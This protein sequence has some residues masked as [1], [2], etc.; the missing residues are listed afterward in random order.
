MGQREAPPS[1]CKHLLPWSRPWAYAHTL[2]L[3]GSAALHGKHILSFLRWLGSRWRTGQPRDVLPKEGKEM[4]AQAAPQTPVAHVHTVLAHLVIWSKG[5][6]VWQQDALRRLYLTGKLLDADLAEL[7]RLC[8]EP[9]GLLGKDESSVTAEPIESAHIPAQLPSS[10]PVSLKLVGQTQN[11]NALAGG[12][13]LNFADSGLTI[14]Y[15]DNG[16]GKSGYGRILKRA[17]RARDQEDILGNVYSPASA[18]PASAHIQ[19]SIGGLPQPPVIWQDGGPAPPELSSISVFDA[20]CA[21]IHVDGRNELAYTPFPLQLLQSLARCCLQIGGALKQK[22]SIVEAQVPPF[23][24]RPASHQGTAV[25]N[26]ILELAPATKLSE[27]RALSQLSEAEHARLKELKRDLAA[28]PIKQLRRCKAL[29]ER[30]EALA[31]SVK[32]AEWTMSATASDGLRQRLKDAKE[33]AAAAKFAA[34][35]AFKGEPLPM[36]GSD[37]WKA[38]WEAARKFSIEEAY[39]AASFPN[40]VAGAVCVLCQQALSPV[41]AE[42]LTRFE[43]F[44][45][46]NAQR[47]ADLARRE[48]E[49]FQSRILGAAAPKEMLREAVSLLRDDLR[50]RDCVSADCAVSCPRAGTGKP[51]DIHDRPSPGSTRHKAR[52]PCGQSRKCAGG[53][54]P[55]SQRIGE[56]AGPDAPQSP[57]GRADWA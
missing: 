17:C 7:S 52:Y 37:V 29:K 28:D 51:I 43:Q 4:T 6:P 20:K 10:A 8:R 3:V 19:F 45:Q 56:G 33:K 26:L 14:V 32:A 40:T 36:V 13:A 1:V 25:H 41:A 27:V 46:Q 57:R 34:T 24:Q 53:C 30:L 22:K 5:L 54:N 39:A 11:V 44:V 47:A 35:E 2:K 49:D 21:S 55:K 50:P 9:H 12:Q 23:R 16:S 42:R 31:V 18:G 15:G 38:L 48:L